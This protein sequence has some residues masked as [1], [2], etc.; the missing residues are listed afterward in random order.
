MSRKASISLS[1]LAAVLLMAS[2]LY[3]LPYYVSKPGM[4]KELEPII[5]VEGG[6]EEEGSFMLTTVRMGRAN[7]YSYIIAKMS[8]YQELYP[9]EDIRAE[10]ESDE[11]YNIRQLHMMDNSKTVAIEVAYKKAGIPVEYNYKGVYVLRIM[12][13]MPAEGKLMPGDLVFEVDGNE[14]ESSDDFIAY[15]SSKKPG[16]IVQLAYKRNGKTNNVEVP[17]KALDDGSERPVVGIQLVDDKEIDV[18][19]DVT[20]HSEEIGGPSAGL[21]FSLEIYN[22][23]IEEDLTKG[24]EIAGTGTMSSDGTV[25]RIG[26]IQQKVVAADKAGAEIF[27]APFEKGA[28]GSNYEEA[29]IAAKDIKTKMKIVPVDTFE[30]A[31]SYLENLNKK[32][33]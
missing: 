26:G 30:E 21:M 20:V 9:V 5:E 31:V 17:L 10:N 15:I 3:Y 19:P 16:D 8:K 32:S 23:L 29:M 14:F 1:I 7:I 33:S 13:G 12:E 2:A 22:Q 25:G 18:D 6:Y 27:F 28:K 4:A 11:E 24:Y